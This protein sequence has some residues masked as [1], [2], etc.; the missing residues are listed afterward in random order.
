M[1]EESFLTNETYTSQLF[2]SLYYA[3]SIII[4]RCRIIEDSIAIKK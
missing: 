3:K 1:A 2:S 4:I